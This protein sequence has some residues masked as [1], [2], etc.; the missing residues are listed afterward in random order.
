MKK[1]PALLLYA[2]ACVT[3]AGSCMHNDHDTSISY[4]ETEDYYSM[5][6]YFS[7]SNTGKVERYMDNQ[8]GSR[9]HMSFKNSRIDGTIGLDDHTKFYIK[10]YPGYLEIKLD[11][12]ANSY[13]SYDEIKSMCQ[14]IKK[15]LTQ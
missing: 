3:I 10:K 5:K 7:K 11:K 12:D 4:K 8:V 6:A 2:F 1:L 13:E 14:G 9:S 15:V